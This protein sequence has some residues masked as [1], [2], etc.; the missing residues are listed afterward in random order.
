MQEKL[1]GSEGNT[2]GIDQP[3][4]AKCIAGSGPLKF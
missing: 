3:F 1:G 2:T 4:E